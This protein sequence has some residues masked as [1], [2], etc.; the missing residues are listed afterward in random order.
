M[1]TAPSTTPITGAATANANAT[2][3]DLAIMRRGRRVPPRISSAEEEDDLA[4]TR[5]GRQVPPRIS[6]AEEE[7]GM[8]DASLPRYE[9]SSPNHP[10]AWASFTF[11][12]KDGSGLPYAAAYACMNPWSGLIFGL[13][14]LQ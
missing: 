7:D 12:T 5:S 4:I 6:S 3:G 14:F 1:A 8:D 10:T 11:G 2:D 13:G 9:T